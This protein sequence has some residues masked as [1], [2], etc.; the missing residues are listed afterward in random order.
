MLWAGATQFVNELDPEGCQHKINYHVRC[1]PNA[2]L[3]DYFDYEIRK[4]TGFNA[5]GW[6]ATG[7]NTSLTLY[8]RDVFNLY[9]SDNPA[10]IMVKTK[11]DK[12]KK[13]KPKQE[14]EGYPED[15]LGED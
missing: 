6:D 3:L 9:T 13:K 14:D 10:A 8:G 1:R 12:P 15:E 4:I 7:Y 2:Y 5:S 11:I